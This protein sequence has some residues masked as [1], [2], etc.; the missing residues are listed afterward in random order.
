MVEAGAIM[1]DE[2][3]SIADE[4]AAL[5]AILSR[6]RE[7]LHRSGVLA[8]L[9]RI[10]AQVP[11]H[12]TAAACSAGAPLYQHRCGRIEA[13]AE[14]PSGGGCDACESGSDNPADWRALYVLEPLPASAAPDAEALAGYARIRAAAIERGDRF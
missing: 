1:S 5:R 13:F 3:A 9:D 6:Q 2:Q 8:R 7:G 14:L 11:Q 4:V 12:A 10:A